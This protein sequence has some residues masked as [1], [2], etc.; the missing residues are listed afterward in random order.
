MSQ[1]EVEVEFE[2][3]EWFFG[4]TRRSSDV[5]GGSQQLGG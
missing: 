1:D 4:E 2:V 5:V 3:S